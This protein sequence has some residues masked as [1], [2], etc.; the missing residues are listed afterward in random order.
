MISVIVPVYNVKPYLKKCLDSILRQSYRDLEILVIDD[1][2]TDG[3]QDICDDFGKTDERIRVFHTENRGLSCARNLGLEHAKGDWIGFIDS[4]DW[5]EPDMFERLIQSASD[6]CADISCC[7]Y[8]REYIDRSEPHLL[9]SEER[10]YEDNEMIAAAMEGSVF[11]HYAWNKIYKRELFSEDCKFPPSMLFEDIATV[12][13]LIVK[14]RRVVCIPDKLYH[15]LIRK[16]S[17]GNTKTMKNLADRWIA[18]KE[19][20][21]KMVPESD[22]LRQICTKECLETIG[23]TWRWL[24]VTEKK[25]R[26]CYEG[27]LR[28]MRAFAKANRSMIRSCSIAT[29]I[30]LFCAIYSNPISVFGCYWLNQ[31]FRRARGLDRMT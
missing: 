7:G 8:D 15:Y 16:D 25:D 30:S 27:C 9:T 23:Y 2:S 26:V 14:C 13:K 31:V 22:K 17:L 24:N 21:E 29:R 18:F 3:S 12:W 19:R 1:G 10:C 5:I 11:G 28:E 20:Y 4:D 6:H